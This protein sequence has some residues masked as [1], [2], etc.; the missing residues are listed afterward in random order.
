M[1]SRWDSKVA[2]SLGSISATLVAHMVLVGAQGPTS[3]WAILSDT[4][5]PYPTD[6]GLIPHCPFVVYLR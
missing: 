1:D 3:L 4:S 2:R 5:G 6:P